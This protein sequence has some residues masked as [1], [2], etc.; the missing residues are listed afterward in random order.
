M[1]ASFGKRL[2]WESRTKQIMLRNFF[3][4]YIANVAARFDAEI[5]LINILKFS[6]Y[7]A[8]KNTIAAEM[9]CRQ[10]ETA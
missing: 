9:F 10:M 8:G 1:V 4:F 7:L 3:W 2:A 5:L 6:I